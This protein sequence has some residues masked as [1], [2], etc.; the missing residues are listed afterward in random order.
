MVVGLEGMV[1]VS[2]KDFVLLYLMAKNQKGSHSERRR[3]RG[4]EANL[5]FVTTPLR[6]TSS[7]LPL[8]DPNAFE[9]SHHP[10]HA[11]LLWPKLNMSFGGDKPHP[12]H[13]RD[14]SKVR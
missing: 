2:G 14:L 13:S 9:K 11:I 6:I 10:F 4:K 12:N 1:L 5:A 3:K 7:F 8:Y